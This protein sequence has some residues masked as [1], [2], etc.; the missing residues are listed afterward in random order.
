MNLKRSNRRT[1]RTTNACEGLLDIAPFAPRSSD[2]RAAPGPSS[3]LRVSQSEAGRAGAQP[4][5][6]R[7][8]ASLPIASAQRKSG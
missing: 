6:E 3:S 1:T 8:A 2:S 4:A 5:W 7:R